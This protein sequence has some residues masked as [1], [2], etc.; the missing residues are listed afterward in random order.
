MIGYVKYFLSIKIQQMYK[1]VPIFKMNNI[2][3]ENVIDIS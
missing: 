1:I 2:N 3:A